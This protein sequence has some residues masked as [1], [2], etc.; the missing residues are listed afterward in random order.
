MTLPGGSGNGSYNRSVSVRSRS[1]PSKS[2]FSESVV[3][4]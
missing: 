1:I 4:S 2:N 3:N